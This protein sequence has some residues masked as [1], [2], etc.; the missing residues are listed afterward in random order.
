MSKKQSSF[1]GLLLIV[2]AP[3]FGVLLA[4]P[5]QAITT[6]YVATNGSDSNPGTQNSPF[7]TLS[8][9]ATKAQA[10]DTVYVRGGT[11]SFANEQ[12]IGSVGTS[13]ASISYQSYPNEKAILDGSRMPAN[14]NL[15]NVAGTY[16]VFKN[17]EL[18]NAKA[19]GL[20]SWGGKNIQF[21]NNVIHDS[22][23]GAIFVGFS[24]MTTTSNIII[25]GNTAYSNCQVNSS[26]TATG[27]WPSAI[28]SMK[29]SKVTI[30]NNRVYQNYGEGI[31]FVLTNDGNAVGNVIYDN[32]SV[33]FYLDNATNITVE[34]NHI[35]TTNNT[36][37]Y[38]FNQ[39]ASGIQA[40]NESYDLS[41]PLNNITIR[42]NIVTGGKTGFAYYS[43]YGKGGGLKNFVIA[44]NTFYKAMETM[45][46]IEKDAGHTNNL[47]ANNIFYQTG[48]VSMT[49]VAAS[50]A[51]A[52]L[53]NN[54]YGGSAG[55]VAGSGDVNADP[56]LV[57]P[58]T[59]VA[60]D[61]KQKAGSPVTNAGTVVTLVTAD[62]AGSSRPLAL[63]YDIGAYEFVQ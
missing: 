23:K 38:R 53:N 39:P 44:N 22:Y 49:S 43:S 61:Y 29:A 20:V 35:Y 19:V 18:K 24:D 17:F 47:I 11:Y 1:P 28:G 45:V 31:N 12:Y 60:S 55:A 8:Y 32:Y 62:Y 21:R 7:A 56:L 3:M 50:P 46:Y 5:A 14:S 16:N 6:Y 54:W 52:F 37:F 26:R 51:L 2:A 9:A 30:S 36:N 59:T 40:A 41:N 4:N 25:D 15:V 10:G 27:G 13:S 34:R 33:N 48:G 63:K 57:N 42:N 58:G